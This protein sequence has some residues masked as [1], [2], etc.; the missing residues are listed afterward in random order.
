MIIEGQQH[1]EVVLANNRCGSIHGATDPKARK[2]AW[3]PAD[4]EILVF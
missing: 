3:G 1:V 2:G 4:R